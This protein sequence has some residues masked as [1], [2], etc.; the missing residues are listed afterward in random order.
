MENK[1][2]QD[3]KRNDDAGLCSTNAT[4]AEIAHDYNRRQSMYLSVKTPNTR[5]IGSWFNRRRARSETKRSEARTKAIDAMLE[6]EASRTNSHTTILFLGDREDDKDF[7]KRL[8]DFSGRPFHHRNNVWRSDIC[9]TVK[10]C[11]TIDHNPSVELVEPGIPFWSRQKSLCHFESVDI[12]LFLADISYYDDILVFG[13]TIVRLKDTLVFWDSI[14]NTPF[15]DGKTLILFLSGVDTFREKLNYTPLFTYFP[16]C[17]V[18]DRDLEGSEQYIISQFLIAN[19]RKAKVYY[20]VLEHAWDNRRLA[21]EVV[22][23]AKAVLVD[24]H[25]SSKT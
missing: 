19:R 24:E 6:H 13:E 22:S 3:S 2:V 8:Q 16:D 18:Q 1:T 11:H 20:R 14:V 4:I 7:M 12:A 5:S 10:G 15:F 17:G 25:S 23:V 9:P 21:E